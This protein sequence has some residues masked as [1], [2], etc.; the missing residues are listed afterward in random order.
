MDELIRGICGPAKSLMSQFSYLVKFSVVSIIIINP[1]IV[2]LFFY[3]TNMVKKYPTP[4]PRNQTSPIKSPVKWKKLLL[5]LSR[6]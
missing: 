4:R 2:S 3:N 6:L 1:L 5:S